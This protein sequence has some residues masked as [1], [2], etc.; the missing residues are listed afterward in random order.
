[1]SNQERQDQM[2]EFIESFNVSGLTRT[3]FCREHNI[4]RPIFYYWFK[5]YKEH[6]LSS[7]GFLQIDATTLH[8]KELMLEII[9]PN[10]VKIITN[11]ST[12]CSDLNRMVSCW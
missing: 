5:R 11:M 4:N 12:S 1:M 9:F 6:Q 7:N 10:G 3:A 2:F 8:T